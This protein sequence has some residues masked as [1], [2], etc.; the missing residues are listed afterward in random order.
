MRWEELGN[1]VLLASAGN[2]G[3]QAVLTI[4][5]NL[6]HEQN[7]NT[8]PLPVIVLDSVSNA[9]PALIPFAPYVLDLLST[10]LSNLL[11]VI[12]PDGHVLRFGNS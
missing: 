1:G 12:E 10:P 5:K 4:D 7:L 9:L 8:L 2:A 3:F 6:R 11:Y